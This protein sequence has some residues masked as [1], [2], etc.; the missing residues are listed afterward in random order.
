MTIC[1]GHPSE[2]NISLIIKTNH[3]VLCMLG[4]SAH[5]PLDSMDSNIV[6]LPQAY[7]KWFIG[8]LK[9]FLLK[10]ASIA[11]QLHS[12]RMQ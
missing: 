3:S 4:V 12:L 1:F 7:K 5:L 10:L 11:S 2:V 8:A 9:I 6:Y